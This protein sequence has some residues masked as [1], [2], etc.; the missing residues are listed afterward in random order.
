MTGVFFDK[1]L[2]YSI[3]DLYQ[4]FISYVTVTRACM[5][6]WGESEEVRHDHITVKT[7][8]NIINWCSRL[9]TLDSGYVLE[10]QEIHL[11]KM[12]VDC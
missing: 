1:G 7:I 12:L 4:L 2:L 5:L 10:S 11:D 6:Y 9:R 3:R 8:M